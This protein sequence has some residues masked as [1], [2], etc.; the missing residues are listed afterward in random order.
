M[1]LKN[2][3]F[4]ILQK[5]LLICPNRSIVNVYGICKCLFF[6]L[7]GELCCLSNLPHTDTPL[8]PALTDFCPKLCIT[9]SSLRKVLEKK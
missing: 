8:A 2:T 6:F 7:E 1:R 4:C 5:P 9:K 3:L